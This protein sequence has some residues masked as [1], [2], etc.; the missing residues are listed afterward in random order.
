MIMSGVRGQ[1]RWQLLSRQ[2]IAD[3]ALPDT[4]LIQP[5]GSIEQ[6]G[7]HLPLDTD[8][9]TAEAIAVRVAETAPF[10]VL[11]LPTVW[12]GVSPYWMKFSGTL[13]VRPETLV[14]LLREIIRATVAHG[15][16]RIVLLNGHAGN[17]GVMH[18]V[19]VSFVDSG[20]RVIGLNYWA[21]ARDLLRQQ[22][23]ADGGAIGHAGEVETSLQLAL[24]PDQVRHERIP[25]NSAEAKPL[26]GRW[27]EA[28]VIPPDPGLESPL[29][30]YGS[31]EAGRSEFG[32]E[33]MRAVTTQLIALLDDFRTLPLAAAESDRRGTKV[34]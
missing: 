7:P 5:I 22:S 24:R 14:G 31:A 10:T 29:G 34:E 32:L 13:S 3:M 6:H 12:W 1:V 4:P 20:V 27:R 23:R 2:D 33:I 21:L 25:A 28:I 8:A 16:R 17:V 11:V 18:T 26:L 30:V 15:F 19:A 9:A